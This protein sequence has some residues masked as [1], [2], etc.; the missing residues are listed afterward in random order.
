MEISG[1]FLQSSC[2]VFLFGAVLGLLLL[3]LISSSSGRP[4]EDRKEPP[5]PKPLPLLGN[6]LQL[7]RKMPYNT[8]VELSKEYGSVFTVYFGLKKVVVLAGYKT[9]KEALVNHAEEFGDRAP[10]L[11]MHELNQGHGILWSNGDSWK[12]M[13][14]FALTNLKDFGMGKRASEDKIIE[15]CDHLIELFSKYKGEAF[16]TTE[17]LNYPVSNII[18]SMVYGSR[19]EYDSP[20]FKS[21]LDRIHRRGPLLGSTS[22]KVYNLFPWTCKWITNRK[23]FFK[24]GDATREQN[25][26]LFSDLK[27]T[28]TPQRCRGFVDAFLVRKQNLE[29]SGITN[30][31]FHDENLLMTVMNLFSAGT[32]TTSTTLRW[33]LLFMAKYPEMQDQVQDELSRVIG[34]RRVQLSDKKNLPFTYAVIHE[35]QRLANVAPI[36]IPHRTSQDVTFQGHFIKKGTTVYPLLTSVLYDENEWESPYTFNPAHFL[37]EDGKFVKRDA[38]MAFSAGRRA[39]VGESLAR[40][41]LF[42]FFTTLLQQF[43][44]TPPPGVSENEMDLT[45]KLLLLCDPPSNTLCAVPRINIRTHISTKIMEIFD[46]FLQ[47][48]GSVSL[49]GALVVLLVCLLFSSSFIIPSGRKEPPG[50]KPLPLLGNL[51]QLNLLNVLWELSKQYGSVFTVYLGSKRVVVLAGYKT[52]K[53]ALVNY[54]DEFGERDPPRLTHETSQGHGVLWSN[55]DSWKAM[56]RFSLTNL[57]DFGIG[58]RACEDK[59]IDECFHLMEVLKKFKG[60]AFDTTQPINYAAS[61]II[62]S[63]VYGSRF[64]YDDHEFTSLVDQSNKRIQLAGSPSIQLYNLFPWIGKWFGNLKEFQKHTDWVLN[65]N[66]ALFR[67]LKETLNPHMCRGF[68]DA[69]LVRKQNL[70]DSGINNSH[71]H[72]DNLMVTVLNVF[73]AG[74]DTTANTLRWA[75]LLMAKYPKIQDRVQEELSRVVGSR[76]VQLEDRKNLPFTDAVIHETQRVGNVVPMSLPHKTTRDVT[77]QGHFIKKGTTVYPLLTSVLY[78]ETEWESPHTFNPAHFLDND[79]KF[80]KRD[81][82]MPFSAGRRICLGESLARMEL[83]IYFTILLQNFRF[84]PPPGVSE[85]DLDLTPRVGFTL[86]PSPH[87]LCAVPCM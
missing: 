74:T 9:V 23:E 60:E 13:R 77:F 20:V 19:F 82:F 69:F 66:L 80:V 3:Y 30:S 70:E 37:N 6:L 78:D 26:K 17:P 87:K 58:K 83:F 8:L 24:L 11:I 46:V 5:G 61:N 67:H 36:A 56:R 1:L 44:F 34:S 15:E 14:R 21:L 53:E 68:V 84:T 79:G 51:L 29:E 4:K 76:P 85:N 22:M 12:E 40:M 54:A 55:G 10:L 63:I 18:C 32:D 73:A 72:D 47:S 42:I 27:E 57:R 48:S 28:L 52:V 38:F 7:D 16:D 31:H 81:A 75:L 2:S 25:I 65:Q 33:G 45:P 62:C 49:L 50:P 64:E 86:S 43:R 39:C 71:F 35:T 59:V 41:E